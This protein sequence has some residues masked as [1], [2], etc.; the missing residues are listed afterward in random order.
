MWGSK[1]R[2]VKLNSYSP[3]NLDLPCSSH[4]DSDILAYDRQIEQDTAEDRKLSHSSRVA[5]LPTKVYTHFSVKIEK[6]LCKN[7]WVG[8]KHMNAWNSLFIWE[9]QFMSYSYLSVRI[10]K[11]RKVRHYQVYKGVDQLVSPHTCD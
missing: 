9:T 4:G 2:R 5:R 3:R 11:V 6:S 8:N 10:T 1:I 7:T